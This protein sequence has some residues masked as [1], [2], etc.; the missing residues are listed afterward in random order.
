MNKNLN[1]KIKFAVENSD[2]KIHK[3]KIGNR[4]FEQDVIT[5]GGKTFQ[6]NKNNV[7]KTVENETNKITKNSKKY[8]A[9][10]II[11]NSLENKDY[12]LKRA[13]KSYAIKSKAKTQML[14][15]LSNHMLI[16]LQFQILN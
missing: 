5:I 2:A 3:A 8:K 16:P 11:N 4:K 12:R 13:L 1:N 15:V 9:I 6:Y 14:K 10:E 7:S